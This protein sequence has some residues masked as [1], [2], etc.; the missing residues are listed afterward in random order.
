[1]LPDTAW[2]APKLD[3]WRAELGELPGGMP[4]AGTPGELLARLSDPATAVTGL[5]GTTARHP[6]ASAPRCRFT[7]DAVPQAS[8]R[9]THEL[10]TRCHQY[11]SLQ[12]NWFSF[13]RGCSR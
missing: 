10:N 3:A 8:A 5:N 2:H 1:M 7:A 9:R 6:D 4:P 11:F 13:E 12:C